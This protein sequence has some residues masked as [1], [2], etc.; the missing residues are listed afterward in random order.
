MIIYTYGGG[1]ILYNIFQGV[2]KLHNGGVLKQLF[3]MGGMMGLTIAVVKAFFSHQSVGELVK[4]WFLPLVIG[5][6]LIFMPKSQVFIKD[7]ITQSEKSVANV[8]YGLALVSKLSSGLGY[9]ITKA[10]ESALRIPDKLSYNTT[11]HIFG[12]EHMMEIANFTWTDPTAEQNMRNF[13]VNC[14]TYDV[15]LGRYSIDNLKNTVDLWPFIRDRTSKN[16]GIYWIQKDDDRSPTATYCSCREAATKLDHNIQTEVAVK[17]K[18]FQHMPI[19]FQALTGISE[20]AE[21]ILR[22]QLMLHSFVEGV[23]TKASSLGLGHNFAVQRAYLQQQSTMMIA[24]GLAGKSVVITRIIFEALIL[25]SF[26]FVVPMLAFPMG[27]QTF[28]RWAEM[29]VWINLWPPVYAVLNFIL[30]S[31]AKSRSEQILKFQ[32]KWTGLDGVG[33]GLSLATATPLANLYNDMV[34]Y[35][36]WASLFVPVLA[37]MI[38]KGGM[39][40]FVHIAGNMMQAS[41]G[42]A[43][44]A[45]QEQV[46]GNYSY[47][48]VSMGNTQYNTAQMNQQGL[49]ARFSDGYM[50]ESTGHYDMT[51]T[52]DGSVM[53]QKVSHLPVNFSVGQSMSNGYQRRAESSMNSAYSEGA[54]M[55]QSWDQAYREMASLDQ[56]MGQHSGVNA[57]Q[58]IGIDSSSQQSMQTVMSQAQT[59]AKKYGIEESRAMSYLAGLN[60]TASMGGNLGPVALSASANLGANYSGSASKQQMIEDAMSIATSKDFTESMSQ[61]KRFSQNTEFSEG[62]DMGKR[63][64]ETMSTSFDRSDHLSKSIGQHLSASETLSRSASY[65]KDNSARMDQNYNDEMWQGF[66]QHVGGNA[67]EAA[68]IY[69]SKEGWAREIVDDFNAQYFQRM[70]QQLMKQSDARLASDSGFHAATSTM[71]KQHD[72]SV[73]K[74]N[75][76]SRTSFESKRAELKEVSGVSAV[77]QDIQTNKETLKVGENDIQQNLKTG[78]KNQK[79]SLDASRKEISKDFKEN[80]DEWITT[81][82]GRAANPFMNLNKTSKKD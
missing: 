67:S 22:Q 27:I 58:S 68:S 14:I 24:G 16:R 23:E 69:N 19:A 46:T 26:I 20:S 74:M 44:A 73:D 66:V 80:D 48:N 43:G 62:Q 18:I 15:M 64:S 2:A 11:G 34:A 61:L 78:L 57:G 82:A 42:A 50:Q 7:I 33:K 32:E 76:P 49:A 31:A 79:E 4:T 71:T 25:V 81:K 29:V 53:D 41:Q 40:S 54:Q 28:V 3:A 37:Y 51:Y 52:P 35:A 21:T 8:P 63:L 9:Q 12:A 75:E 38:L 47:G 39:A 70:E 30:Q 1:D 77:D 17:K 10:I 72:A 5:Y 65:A 60:G 56:H 55:N 36:G 13:V 45:A 59:F 6:G